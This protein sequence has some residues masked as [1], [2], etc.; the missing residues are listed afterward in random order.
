ME[1]RDYERHARETDG[2][3]LVIYAPSGT[4]V[5]DFDWRNAA[6]QGMSVT[7]YLRVRAYSRIGDYEAAVI[8]GH[9]YVPHGRTRIARVRASY[10]KQAQAA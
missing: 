2:V 10:E 4:Q 3:A 8:D 6:D 9:G 1:V 5:G 7:E